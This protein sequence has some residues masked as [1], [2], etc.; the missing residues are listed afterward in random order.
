MT[1]RIKKDPRYRTIQIDCGK[2]F[3]TWF[4]ANF[5]R[6]DRSS[7]KVKDEVEL[8]AGSTLQAAVMRVRDKPDL[9][10]EVWEFTGFLGGSKEREKVEK[11][12]QK[13]QEE[14]G[15]PHAVLPE[16]MTLKAAKNI[17]EDVVAPRVVTSPPRL[18]LASAAQVRK[19]KAV[20]DIRELAQKYDYSG[21]SERI[22]VQFVQRDDASS[23]RLA[24]SRHGYTV[25]PEITVAGN[26]R[27]AVEVHLKLKP[28]KAE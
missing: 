26:G 17:Q 14:L 12:W 27:H 23:F 20:D 21:I 8:L 3:V 13:L 18:A 19:V 22:E 2:V 11:E 6:P 1:G 5:K 10:E 24:A 7:F 16:S 28:S 9:K 4:G 25:G 15:H